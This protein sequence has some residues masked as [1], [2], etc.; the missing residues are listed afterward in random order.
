MSYFGLLST[1]KTQRQNST[2]FTMQISFQN[3]R[4]RPSFHTFQI[5]S[6][7][8]YFSPV[9][10]KPN[11]I[12]PLQISR[13]CRYFSLVDNRPNQISPLQISRHSRY[14]SLL[15]NK[16]NQI[17]RLQI[18]SQSRFFHCRYQGIVYSKPKCIK[19]G[20][21]LNKY[22]ALTFNIKINFSFL[23]LTIQ[24]IVHVNSIKII[25]IKVYLI[26]A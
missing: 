20:Y 2:C 7:S 13:Q 17:S 24:R 21:F 10:N 16:P 3:K 5:R 22:A 8:R 23:S 6:Q 11:Q 26:M 12:S 9:V 4:C 19:I 18:T 1:I 15:D 14:F 25:I